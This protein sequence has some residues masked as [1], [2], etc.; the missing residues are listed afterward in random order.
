MMVMNMKKH[1]NKIV[2]LVA[3]ILVWSVFVVWD[4]GVKSVTGDYITVNSVVALLLA[5]ICTLVLYG[6]HL[7]IPIVLSIFYV[8]CEKRIH[9]PQLSKLKNRLWVLGIWVIGNLFIGL[10]LYTSISLD[11]SV[12]IYDE[13]GVWSKGMEYIFLVSAFTGANIQIP[14][15]VV[16]V[17]DVIALL[18]EWKRKQSDYVGLEQCGSA[19]D[20]EV[21]KQYAMLY[22]DTIGQFRFEEEKLIAR[23]PV[24]GD[25][26]VKTEEE[27]L[28]EQD[29]VEEKYI[30]SSE[31]VKKEIIEKRGITKLQESYN[32]GMECLEQYVK[33]LSEQEN[34]NS[35]V[36]ADFYVRWLKMLKKLEITEAYHMEMKTTYDNHGEEESE[37][38]VCTMIKINGD[39]IRMDSI[40]FF[41]EDY[42]L[43]R[44]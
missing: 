12:E 26:K 32:Q 44:I 2:P 35:K 27:W 41:N 18:G 1:W 17:K 9:N 20:G 34:G 14:L 29:N 37:Y 39:W 11:P 13:E 16:F 43:E 15:L 28:E 42:L 38:S 6:V 3:V 25:R 23:M 31:I 24:E 36:L 30:F 19:E 33:Y 8:V 5:P 4:Y 22:G 21:K 10:Y 40:V 7:L